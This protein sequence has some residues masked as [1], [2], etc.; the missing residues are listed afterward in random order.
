MISLYQLKQMIPD[1]RPFVAV[2]CLPYLQQAMTEF[3][4]AS[5]LQIAA[6]IAQIGHESWSL[7]AMFEMGRRGKYR[8]RGAIQL[9]G[10]S[11]Y[12]D[13]GNKMNATFGTNLDLVRN[14][15]QAA[16]PQYCFRIA[17]LFWRR[18]WMADLN[19]LAERVRSKA[20]FDWIGRVIQ[21]DYPP[22]GHADR[23]RRYQ[24]A[25]RV[26]ASKAP[27]PSGAYCVRWDKKGNWVCNG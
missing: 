7:N 9:T 24:L 26:V 8:G 23:W 18:N 22:D 3:G 19:P 14:P 25:L 12:R 17:G 11:N 5:A 16:D 21:G 20:E 6:F 27:Q 10:V 13:Y 2:Q 1:V 15:N 4:I